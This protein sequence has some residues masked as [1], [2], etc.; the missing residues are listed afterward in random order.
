MKN[1]L[2]Y[3]KK[4]EKKTMNIEWTNETF[5]SMLKRKEEK[6]CHQMTDLNFLL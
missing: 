5:Q 3:K 4:R 6:Y 1:L 2:I